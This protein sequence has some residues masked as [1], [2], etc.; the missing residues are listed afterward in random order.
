MKRAALQQ[1]GL[2]IVETMIFLA[3]TGI[4]VS[5]ALVLFN[6][7]IARAQ[8]TQAVQELDSRIKTAINEVSAGTYPTQPSYSCTVSGTA[9]PSIQT[10]GT[11]KQGANTGCIFL[12]KVLQPGVS[13]GGCSATSLKD[14]TTLNIYTVFGRR[15]APND[16]NKV[17]DSMTGGASS[18]G[19]RPKI[20]DNLTQSIKLPNGLYVT[21]VNLNSASSPIGA[22]AVLQSL[23][24]YTGNALN[25][26][27]QSLDTW[28][29]SSPYPRTSAQIVSAVGD[30]T[31]SATSA[32]PTIVICLEG[33][34]NQKASIALGADKGTLT[35]NVQFGSNSAC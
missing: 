27:A 33:G 17:A 2:T 15:T 1:A 13:G 10:G 5:S 7:R 34:I 21:S 18:S 25:A 19:V 35:T 20:A 26:G 32:N 3:V 24:T 23:G 12:G 8:F 22:F 28:P 4:L 9:A 31:F 29:V 11:T 6:G 30:S 16:S 14:C